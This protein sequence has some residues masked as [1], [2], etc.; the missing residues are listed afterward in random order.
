MKS[1]F[2]GIF[3]LILVLVLIFVFGGCTAPQGGEPAAEGEQPVQEAAEPVVVRLEGG[4][5]GYPTP[6]AHYSRGP[7]SAKMRYIFDT[8]LEKDEKGYIPWLA[9][10]WEVLDDGRQY[11]FKIRDDVCWQDGEPLTAHD[12]EFTLNYYQEN[13]PVSIN[14]LLLDKDFLLEVKA[15]SDYEVQFTTAETNANFLEAAGRVSIIPA[16]IWKDVQT[17]EEFLG[18]AAVIGSG[19]FRL[20][21]YNKEHGTYRF[22]ANREFWGPRPRVDV[23]EFIPVSDPILALEKG[24]IDIAGIPADVLSRFEDKA[25]FSIMENP[26]FWGYRLRFNMQKLPEFQCKELRQ[27]FAYA[28]NRQE[29]VDKNA[30]G[31]AIPGSMG[32]LTPHH[33]WY[34][35]ALPPYKHD[36][37]KARELLAGVDVKLKP[38]YELLVGGDTEVRIGELIKGQ[39]AAV[40]IELRVTSVDMKA[41]DARIAEG[42]YELVLVGHGGWGGDP[43]YLRTRFASAEGSWSSG[44]PGYNHPEVNRLCQEQ[45]LEIDEN[46][47]KKL[48]FQLQQVLAEEVPEI[49][50]YLTTGH[51]VFRHQNYDGWMHIFDHH[52]PTHNKLSYLERK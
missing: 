1:R 15:L 22:E 34:N 16:H 20:V 44:T 50:L 25:E 29:L 14:A 8:L 36:P 17:P 24:E 45:L 12:V 49:S 18:P 2:Y 26:A 7:G 52:A 37:Q 42:N 11:L 31:E 3:S 46:K 5:W 9:W 4:D 30:R 27:A 48:I 32:V 10:D 21:D 28:V 38:A 41:R 6:F 23:L 51:N 19:P 13:H 39:F 35:P 43:D 47:R 33:R 40:G